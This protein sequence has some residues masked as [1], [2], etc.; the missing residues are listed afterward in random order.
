MSDAPADPDSLAVL[1]LRDRD[2]P[3]PGC[4]YNRRDATAARCPECGHLLILGP[5]FP[6]SI[7]VRPSTFSVV[8]Y[9]L[10]GCSVVST[11]YVGIYVFQFLG[12][13]FNPF[14]TLL[15]FAFT[16]YSITGVASIILSIMHIL[17]SR[18]D[19]SSRHRPTGL[20]VAA[21]FVCHSGWAAFL[22]LALIS[23][24]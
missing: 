8:A 7:A 13:P 20:L 17:K 10:L 4:G 2:L 23:T 22:I 21:A 16:V 3:C 12:F 11:L 9:S 6:G 1:Y 5:D 18:A 24:L 15:E 19:K 14:N